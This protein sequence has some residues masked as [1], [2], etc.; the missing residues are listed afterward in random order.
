MAC[1]SRAQPLV[2]A[3]P[4]TARQRAFSRSCRKNVVHHSNAYHD[5]S[6]PYMERLTWGGVAIHAGNLPGYPESHGCVHVPLDFAR[7]LYTITEKGTTVFVTDEKAQTSMA[8]QSQPGLL[9]SDKAGE[10]SPAVSQAGQSTPT[11]ANATGF[12]WKPQAAPTGPLSL[13]FSTADKQIYV[14]RDG[15]EIGRTAVGG[16]DSGRSYGNHVYTALAR[17]TPD[18]AHQWSALGVGDGPPAPASV[19]SGNIWSF[20]RRSSRNYAPWLSPAPRS[21]LP[22]ITWIPPCGAALAST[23]WIRRIHKLCGA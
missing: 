22:I 15:V 23:S 16:P 19:K 3:N 18:G 2:P 4:G 12:A 7:K 6:M 14:Y 20:L 21:S 9:F 13:L 17:T 8:S 5:A 11:P 10:P 1:A